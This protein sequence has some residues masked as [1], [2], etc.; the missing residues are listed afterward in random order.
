MM[1]L[2]K[3]HQHE[4]CGGKLLVNSIILM[5]LAGELATCLSNLVQIKAK[6]KDKKPLLACT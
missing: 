3:P 5:M 1:F 2:P 6:S 4:T